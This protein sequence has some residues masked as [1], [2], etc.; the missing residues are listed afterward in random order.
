MKMGSYNKA[1]IHLNVLTEN[2]LSCNLWCFVI[3]A[4]NIVD[5]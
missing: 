4:G 3:L 1:E 2:Q 5:V